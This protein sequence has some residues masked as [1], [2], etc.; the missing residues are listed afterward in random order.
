MDDIAVPQVIATMQHQLAELHQ[1][2]CQ[3]AAA[4][5]AQ[6]VQTLA[7]LQENLNYLERAYRSSVYNPHEPDGPPAITAA[8]QAQQALRQSEERYR[9]IV[10][11]QTELI[12]RFRPDFTLTFVNPAYC[13]L[14]QQSAEAL[15]G[16]DLLQFVHPDDRANLLTHLA[17]ITPENPV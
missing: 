16:Q 5:P 11:N 6:V 10:D 9:A 3:A 2:L 4:P 13:R 14:L 17:L 15:I 7:S 1:D 12:V 8:Q